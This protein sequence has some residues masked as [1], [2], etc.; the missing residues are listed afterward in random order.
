MDIKQ[1]PMCRT[2]AFA[3]AGMWC[4]LLAGFSRNYHWKDGQLKDTQ[5]HCKVPTETCICHVHP[6]KPHLSAGFTM[7]SSSS[8]GLSSGRTSCSSLVPA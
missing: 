4:I 6:V 7:A 5:L 3:A 1:H 8:D 2:H